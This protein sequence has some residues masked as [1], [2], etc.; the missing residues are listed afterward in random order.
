MNANSQLGAL[1]CPLIMYAIIFS[2]VAH[3]LNNKRTGL[4]YED[5]LK[6]YKAFL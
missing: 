3:Y 6:E 1:K 5:S 2:Y 4:R